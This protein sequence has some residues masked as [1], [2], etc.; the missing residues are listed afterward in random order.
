[1]AGSIC[2]S[3]VFAYLTYPTLFCNNDIA[4][5][6]YN[7]ISHTNI[8]N[9]DH[10]KECVNNTRSGRVYLSVWIVRIS[11]L[12]NTLLFPLYGGILLMGRGLS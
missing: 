12:Y 8:Y 11:Q 4:K 5:D 2:L 10:D 9:T 1:M 7:N 6:I 3:W